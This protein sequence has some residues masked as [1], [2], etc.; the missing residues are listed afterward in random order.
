MPWGWVRLRL[1]ILVALAGVIPA[2]AQPAPMELL[3]FERRK[4]AR[5]SLICLNTALSCEAL[6]TS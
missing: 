4:V 6:C 3:H 2:I 5:F 1:G